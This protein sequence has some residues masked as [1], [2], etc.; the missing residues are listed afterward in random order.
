MCHLHVQQQQKDEDKFG[1]LVIVFY[2]N[3]TKEKYDNELGWLIVIYN[4]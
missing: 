2:L 1:Q 4:K 3:A